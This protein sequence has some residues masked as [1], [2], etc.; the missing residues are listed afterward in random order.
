MDTL[1]SDDVTLSHDTMQNKFLN[2]AP[3]NLKHAVK[4]MIKGHL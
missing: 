4:Y 1:R 3:L 2:R